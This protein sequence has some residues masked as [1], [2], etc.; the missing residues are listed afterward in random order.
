MRF[1][2]LLFVLSKQLYASSEKCKFRP[3]DS[4]FPYAVIIG[5]CS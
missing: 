5:I 3:T 2:M 4:A 1:L